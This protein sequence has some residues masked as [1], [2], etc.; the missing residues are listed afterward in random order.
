MRK[1]IFLLSSIAFLGTT[2]CDDMSRSD[3][4]LAAGIV[5]AGVGLI[6]AN[7]LEADRNWTLLAVLAGAAIG[8]LV[9]RNDRTNECAY[10]AGNGRYRVR[11][12][13]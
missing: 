11:P 8:T 10:A 1:M 12:C 2:A 7:V 5:G 4:V 3:R 13:G 9:A 6:T